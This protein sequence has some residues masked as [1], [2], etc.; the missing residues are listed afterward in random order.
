MMRRGMRKRRAGGGK[1]KRPS[2]RLGVEQLEQRVLLTVNAGPLITELMAAND[3]V[4]ADEDGDYPDWI[5]IHNPTDTSIPLD[6]WYLTDKTDELTSW[7][8]PAVTLDAGDYLV[9]FASEKDRTD[10]GGPLH[11]NF[12]LDSD[13]EYLALV[14]PDGLTRAHEFAPQFPRQ[15]DDISYGLAQDVTTLVAEGASVTTWVPA[16]DSLGADWTSLAFNDTAW[17][18]GTTGLGF[19]SGEGQARAIA[20]SDDAGNVGSQDWTGSLGLDFVVH[21]TISVTQLG[22]F[23][24]N[25]DGLMRDLT[26]QM[27]TRSGDSGSLLRQLSFTPADPGTLLGGDRFKPLGTPLVLQPG[28]YTIVAYGYGTG[29]PNGNAGGPSYSNKHTDDGGG[30]IEFVGG[31]RAGTAGLFPIWPDF[32]PANRYS[33]GTFEFAV[34]AYSQLIATDLEAAMH[35]INASVYTRIEFQVGDPAQFSSLLLQTKYDDGFVAHLNG[36]EIVR[37]NAPPAVTFNSSAET[38]R[39]LEDSLAFESIN[40]TANMDVLES[41]TNVLAIHGLNVDLGDPDFLLLPTLLGVDASSIQ[42]RYFEMPT[43]GAPNDS[44]ATFAGL[45][46]DLTFSA[47]RGFFDAPLDVSITTA[48]QGAEIYYTTDGT[49]PGPGNGDVYSGPIHVDATTTL[50]A[51]GYEDDF[52][53]TSTE[54]HTYVFLDDVLQ[55]SGVPEGYP[56]V[57][58]GGYVADYAM[59]QNAAD[60]PL[61]AGDPTYTEPQYNQVIKDS[62]LSLPTMSIVLPSDDLFDPITGIYVNPWGRGELW[63]RA[64]SVEYFFPDGTEGFQIDGGLR[65][66]GGT[67]RNLAV[68][69]KLSFRIL[70][71]NEY[72]AG[73]LNYPFFTDSPI[74]SYNTIALRSNTRDS[75]LFAEGGTTPRRD[76]LFFR[77]QWAKLAQGDMGQ[78]ASSGNFVHLYINGMYWGMYNPTERPDGAFAAEHLGGDDSD[79]DAVKFCCPQ[80]AVDG[81]LNK[82]TELKDLAR[83]GLTSDAA[84]QFIQ[85]NNPDGTRN[86]DYEVL[87]DIDNLIDYVI[88]GQYHAALDWPGNYYVARDRRPQSTGFKFFTWDNDLAFPYQ[89]LYANKTLSDNNF[90]WTESPGV[91]D[92]AL[93]SNAEYR[94]RFADHVQ[95]HFFNDGSLT[96]AA[97]AGLFTEI[98]DGIEEALIA[99]SA[100][101]GDYRRDVAPSGESVL[102]T[103]HNQWQNVKSDMLA[104][105]FPYRRDVVLDQLRARSLYPSIDAPA[106]NQHGGEVDPGFLLSMNN[107]N[108]QGDIYFTT[109][110]SDPRLLGGMIHGNLYTGPLT[111]DRSMIIKAR[112]LDG[113]TW[114]ALSEAE[115]LVEGLPVRH[116]LVITE[117][118]YNPAVPTPDEMAQGFLDNN[119]FE[120]I[121]LHNL[122]NG[123][124]DLRGTRLVDGIGFEFVDIPYQGIPVMITE[125]GTG[126]PDYFEIQNVSSEVVNTTGWVAVS[127]NAASF[128]INA[129][130]DPLWSFPPSMA[131]GELLY[132]EDVDGDDIFWRA[133]DDGWVMILD[134]QG[135]IVDFVIW[136]YDSA[137]MADMHVEVNGFAGNPTQVAWSG[138]AV[139]SENAAS[140]ALQRIGDSDRDNLSDWTFDV[141][142]SGGSVNPGLTVPFR[143]IPLLL[144]PGAYVVLVGNTAAFRSRY[145]PTVAIAGQYT[146]RLKNEGER[147]ELAG[148]L[149]QTW[150][151]FTYGDSRDAGW[152]DRA[153][154]NGATLEVIDPLADYNDPANWRSSGEYLGTPG[155]AGMGPYQGIVVNEVLTH[156]DGPSVDAIEL[157]NPTGT[158]VVLDG[159]WLSDSSNDLLK[160]QIPTGTTIPALGYVTFYEGHYVGQTFMVNQQTEFGGSGVKD[161][162]LSGSRGDDVWL[163]MDPGGGSSLRFA[164]HLEFGGALAGEPF[165]RWPYGTGNLYPMTY[166]TPDQQNS[167]PRLPQEVVISE[168]M[169]NTTAHPVNLTGWRLRKGFDYDFAPGTILDGMSAIVIVSFDPSDQI[170]LDAFRTAYGIGPEVPIVGNPN[171]TL[172]DTDDRIQLQRPDTP[173]PNDPLYVPHVIEDEIDYLNSWHATTDG[174]GDSLSRTAR[175]DWGNDASSWTAELPTPGTAEQFNTPGVIGRYVFY[176]NSS[177][178]NTIA[179]DKAA[180]QPGGQASFAN[181]TSYVHGINGIIIDISSLTTPGGID[182]SD[183]T[184]KLGN[185]DTPGNWTDAPAPA[186]IDATA[187]QI[188]LTWN[189]GV[190]RNTWLEVTVLANNDT[191]LGI[192]DVFYFGNAPGETGDSLTDA[193]VDAI[194]VL[195]TRQ[196]PQPFFDPATIDNVYDFNRDRRVNAI[197]TLIA[198]NNQTWSG[199]ELELIDLSVKRKVQSGKPHAESGSLSAFS[200][201]L[202]ALDWVYEFEPLGTGQVSSQRVKPVS[203]VVDKLPAELS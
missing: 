82:W 99:E 68:S 174:G 12:K 158:D 186:S 48:T 2:R 40:L 164:D 98:A 162:A 106:Y 190:I 22:V 35:E 43:P 170:K 86:P 14:E 100:R 31:G 37:R 96:P 159:W 77:D 97:A 111:I 39:P 202:S 115:F 147:I 13:G 196:N 123:T 73:R 21:D 192:P 138:P 16:D 85:G 179:P 41:G 38:S 188:V 185:D 55:Q 132:R 47:R 151:E 11:T 118:N 8:F 28:D 163:L 181:Y 125:T 81:D 154:G 131:P 44:T 145:G 75:W 110:D 18:D 122:G 36:T 141:S 53:P 109:D 124:L 95:R 27:W 102:Y 63:E 150:M 180:L 193:T 167:G 168:V 105:Y 65:I 171:D 20:Y 88:N 89:N 198:R 178:G 130:H 80:R 76:S 176:N 191:G 25:S 67:S 117:I 46:D 87:I 116:D 137:A 133:N 199:T 58:Q 201:R 7:Q 156:T 3:E 23:D 146:G 157:F 1:S 184:F 134:Q 175:T 84:Y 51:V 19:E 149:G 161:F 6:G 129:V 26:A 52:Y 72:G 4:L 49:V 9:V 177:L 5:E 66:M 143:G 57:W 203:A 34:P 160:F 172:R 139:D 71:K 69:P 93:R 107:P 94:L 92:I 195:A 101:W 108:G 194:D 59:S 126:T 135:Q 200:S 78:L 54:T 30:A 152:P 142:P 17:T 112:V 64:A 50:R 33:A 136:G 169:Y 61:I 128:Q 70:F 83:A 114:S 62:L 127:N 113:A 148:S 121:E 140:T 119:D 60:L 189:D 165:G 56:A 15:L 10:P 173:P 120:F 29:E 187:N 182:A 103:P 42:P 91:L 90:W 104:N 79:Y 155:R 74:D 166:F 197:D 144:E 32:G 153:D 45:V 183:F 24:S